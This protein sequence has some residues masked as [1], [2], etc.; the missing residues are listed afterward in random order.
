MCHFRKDKSTK[1]RNSHTNV[2]TKKSSLL[3]CPIKPCVEEFMT[4]DSLN[5]H[6]IETHKRVQ[7]TYCPGT[8][9]VLDLNSH[10]KKMHGI[11][12]NTICEHCGQV[13][14]N[15]QTY[16][17][18]VKSIHEVHE[19]LQCDICKDWFK[20]RNSVR[21]HMTY[22]HIQSP[23]ACTI[24]G[25]ISTNRKA[26]LKHKL[27]HIES[28]KDRYKC[29]VCG[30][31]FRDNTKLK[32]SETALN[33]SGVEFLIFCFIFPSHRNILIFIVVWPMRIHAIFVVKTFVSVRLYQLTEWKL[34][35][36]KWQM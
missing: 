7:C 4:R 20:S 15:N 19:L 3:K 31:G 18:H 1:K 30:K 23:Q 11:I 33:L 8:K 29:I 34:I 26:L 25:K 21:S 13:F 10:Y 32:V 5:T 24:C 6:K 27:I 16:L 12:Q 36:S 2:Q 9:L 28:R 35:L 14:Q 22:V 17:S